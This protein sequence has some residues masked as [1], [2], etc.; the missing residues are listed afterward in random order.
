MIKRLKIVMPMAAG[1]HDEAVQLHH[2]AEN[3]R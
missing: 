3:A 2:E 1:K